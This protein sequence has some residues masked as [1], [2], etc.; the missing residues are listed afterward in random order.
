MQAGRRVP[1]SERC[2]LASRH[3][4][5]EPVPADH[6]PV[7]GRGYVTEPAISIRT[8]MRNYGPFNARKVLREPLVHFFLIGAGLFAIGAARGDSASVAPTRRIVVDSGQI[9]SLI[10]GWRRTW[11]RPPTERE[12]QGLIDDHLKEEIYYREAMALGLDRDDAII[13]RRLRQKIE[14]LS[15][16]LSQTI[17]PTDAEL[18][19]YLAEHPDDYRLETEFTLAHRYFNA[20]DGT[21]TA[22]EEARR[23]LTRLDGLGGGDAA[24]R[25]GD[26]LPLPLFFE[27]ATGRYL[28]SSFGPDFLEGVDSLSV[29]SWRGPIRSG[30]GFH[31]VFVSERTEGRL[32]DLEEVR[33]EVERDWRFDKQNQVQSQLFEGL[34]EQYLISVDWPEELKFMGED[35]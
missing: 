30:Y 11:Q 1:A 15:G 3:P 18:A 19:E 12:L 21:E 25:V 14:F 35:R 28:E 9:V 2:R 27:D 20:D 17:A 26:P 7:P 6:N 8:Y 10:E 34:R 5:A 32:P 24:S 22:L 33:L 4:V 29:G 16:D 31:V 13:R 23:S